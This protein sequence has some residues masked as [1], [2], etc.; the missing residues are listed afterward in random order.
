MSDVNQNL[1]F[2]EATANDAMLLESLLRQLI[3]SDKVSVLPEQLHDIKSRQ[4]NFVFV[5][6]KDQNLLG[7]VQLTLCPDIMFKKAALCSAGEYYCVFTSSRAG[8]RTIA[9]DNS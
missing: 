5:V 6:E 8:C 7:M 9:N 2:R 1:I 3:D 4:D